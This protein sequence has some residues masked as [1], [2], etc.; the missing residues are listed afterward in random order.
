MVA[1]PQ[2]TY[3][4]INTLKRVC[5][6]V[7]IVDGPVIRFGMPWPKL[8][9]TTRM[10]IVRLDGELFIH[11]P[12]PLTPTLARQIASIGRPRWLI[13]PN[14]IHYWWL[15]IWKAAY[16]RAE[17]W[18]APRIDKHAKGRLQFTPRL[19]TGDRGYPWDSAIATLPVAGRFMTEFEFFHRPSRTLVLTDLIENFEVAKLDSFLVRLLV[20]AAGA[21]APNGQM[22][23]DMRLTFDRDAI[24]SAA[25]KMI[26]WNPERV[27]FAHGRWYESDGAA[28]LND[29]FRWALGEPR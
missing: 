11:S 27:I 3:A 15:G 25:R 10:T 14:R 2:A 8:P 6:D 4:P 23:R 22:P 28:R 18:L 12:T 24:R 9:F 29:G 21:L 20:R 7:W 13:G 17:P 19:L 5:D 26:E 16:P 1:S